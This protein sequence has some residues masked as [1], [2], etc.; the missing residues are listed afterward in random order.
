MFIGLSPGPLIGLVNHQVYVQHVLFSVN[1]WDVLKIQKLLCYGF[2][3]IINL[4][5]Q[6]ATKTNQKKI[7][8]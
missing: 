2:A 6:L 1:F 8:L 4:Q 7:Y 5:F 3:R